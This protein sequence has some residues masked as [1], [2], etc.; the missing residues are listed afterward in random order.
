MSSARQPLFFSQLVLVPLSGSA[1]V[2]Y[3]PDPPSQA[4]ALPT[5]KSFSICAGHVVTGLWVVIG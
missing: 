1:P 5:P 2:L 3:L 4:E